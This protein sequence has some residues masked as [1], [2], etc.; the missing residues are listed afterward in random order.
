MAAICA[1]LCSA[2][3][4]TDM[5]TRRFESSVGGSDKSASLPADV[6]LASAADF[7]IGLLH[8]QPSSLHL[9]FEETKATLEPRVMQALLA[10]ATAR[11]TVVS[12]DGLVNLCWSGRAVSEDAINRC[13]AK[14]RRI[15]SQSR[16]F[17]IETIP[18]VGYRLI[19]RHEAA[20]AARKSKRRARWSLVGLALLVITLAG[21][22]WTW[23]APAEPTAPPI[24]V[25]NF[26]ALNA[27]ADAKLYADS[28]STSLSSA[29]VATGASLVSRDRPVRSLE[30]A[31]RAGAALLINGT[32]RRQGDTIQIT[33]A[34]DS[35]R[36]GTTVLTKD[37]EAPIADAGALPDR[38]AGALAS[39]LW[40]WIADSRIERDPAVNEGILRIADS[41]GSLKSLGL[42]RDL[43]RAKPNSAAA[44]AD[45]AW[46]TADTLSQIPSEQRIGALAA[47]RE[48]AR[49][50]TKLRSQFGYILPCILT[51]PSVPSAD[52]DQALRRAVRSDPEPPFT[53]YLFAV[54]LAESG[55]LR[56]AGTVIS[57]ALSQAPYHSV[58]L[59]FRMFTL[60]M[61]RPP[62]YRNELPAMRALA[63][64]Y[65]PDALKDVNQYRAAVAN[66]DL[67]A[68]EAI[69]D[70]PVAG[71][72]I[73][74]NDDRALV[75]TLFRAI[76]SRQ[77]SDISTA[78]SGCLPAPLKWG[79]TDPIFGTCLV[80]LTLLGDLDGTFAVAQHYWD[81]ECCAAAQ[82]E[83]RW[84]ASGGLTYPTLE[85]FGS[86]MAPAR[87]DRRFI[88]VA[89]RTG[90]LAYWKSGYP[91]DFCLFERVPVCALFR[92]H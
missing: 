28:V 25:A 42:A 27:D 74:S 30:D 79:P 15:G 90:L 14:V 56:D 91:P 37:F 29:L 51:P 73:A 59:S 55:R 43:A 69:L 40:V 19:E 24:A 36:T 88:E 17:E 39:T 60:Q 64:R 12:R 62:D 44:Q 89:R 21:L 81:V 65:A 53:S 67:D 78:R 50:A 58:P 3:G 80:G 87:A 68:A 11:G 35:T 41:W 38:V 77:P 71:Q 1:I 72:R 48:S 66:G 46:I 61:E 85:L 63:Q 2:R 18:R 92:S 45:F 83:E 70:D 7:R 5:L 76:R 23:R 26:T 86:A 22:L 10:L 20:G 32:V 9:Q 34:V 47:A 33:A 4:T 31:R 82:L 13:I 49:R 57:G 54:Q 84:R 75:K 52:C 8:A 6:D 16:A